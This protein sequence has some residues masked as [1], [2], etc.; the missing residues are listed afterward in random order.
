MR[1]GT[2]NGSDRWNA[3]RRTWCAWWCSGFGEGG[4]ASLAARIPPQTGKCDC[5]DD[6]DGNPRPQPQ[7]LSGAPAKRPARRRKAVRAVA[8]RQLEDA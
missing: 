7:P 1:H 5:R 6:D 4:L 3:P 2:W 8:R